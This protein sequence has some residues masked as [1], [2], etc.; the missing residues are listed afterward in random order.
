MAKLLAAIVLGIVLIASMNSIVQADSRDWTLQTTKGE[1]F[2]LSEHLG[3]KPVVLVFWATWCTPCKK[4]LDEQRGL[5]DSL[6]EEG[7][8]VV[9]VS[10]DNQK[11]Q[12]KVKPYVESKGYQ[13][14]VLLDPDNE[15]LKRYG[16]INVPYTVVLDADGNA[17]SKMRTAIKDVNQFRSLI[18][19][20][21]D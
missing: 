18:N 2:N 5:F 11:S 20:L 7:V 10:V 14:P 1:Q 17:Q 15:V 12:A 8:Q 9:L 19:S 4:E 21:M 16:G 3:G 13:W 6:T